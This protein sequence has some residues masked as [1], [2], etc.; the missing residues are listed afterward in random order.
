MQLYNMLDARRNLSRLIEEPVSGGE[1][2][3]LPGR[4]PLARWCASMWK[5]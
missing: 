1:P 4:H 3:V 2:F 5:Q